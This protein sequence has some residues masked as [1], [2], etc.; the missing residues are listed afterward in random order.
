[1]ICWANTV[2]PAVPRALVD[3]LSLFVPTAI[4]TLVSL[5]WQDAYPSM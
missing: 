5:F 2:P 4:D 3:E 1:M